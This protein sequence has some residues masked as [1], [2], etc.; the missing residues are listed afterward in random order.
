MTAY[1]SSDTEMSL[2]P[3]GPYLILAEGA[4]DLAR[5]LVQLSLLVVGQGQLGYI[6]FLFAVRDVKK[7]TPV[8]WRRKSK[9]PERAFGFRVATGV[10]SAQSCGASQRLAV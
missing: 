3:D 4:L 1:M 5:C 2:D 9:F 8:C 7:C 6:P 10:A